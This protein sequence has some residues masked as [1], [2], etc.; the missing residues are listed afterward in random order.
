M[1][2]I[3]LDV[4][5]VTH[6]C[7]APISRGARDRHIGH[8]GDTV[9]QSCAGQHGAPR[10]DTSVYLKEGRILEGFLVKPELG[11]L[12]FWPKSTAQSMAIPRKQK[13]A[14]EAGREEVGNQA[15]PGPG[16]F[17]EEEL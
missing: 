4:T 1:P 3:G 2:S 14:R 13:G 6:T 5:S 9:V 8:Y 10:R 17:R 11:H 16:V 12:G 15:G 7:R